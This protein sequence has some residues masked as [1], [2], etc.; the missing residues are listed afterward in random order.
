[1]CRSSKKGLWEHPA[2][3]GTE[4]APVMMRPVHWADFAAQ[5]HPARKSSGH[6]GCLGS[7]GEREEQLTPA[8]LAPGKAKPEGKKMRAERTR[9]SHKSH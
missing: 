5:G 6:P 8:E 9:R 1:M 3:T 7:A 4:N 2:Q